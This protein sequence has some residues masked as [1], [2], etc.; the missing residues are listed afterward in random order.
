VVHSEQ[1]LY[2]VFEYLNQDLKKYMDSSP[3]P[4]L[5][6]PLVKVNTMYADRHWATAAKYS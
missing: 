1:K 6:P 2:L 3:P 4:G 5:P